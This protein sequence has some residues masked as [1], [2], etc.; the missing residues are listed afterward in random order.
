[1]TYEQAVGILI[2]ILRSKEA[3]NYEQAAVATTHYKKLLTDRWQ[4][5]IAGIKGEAGIT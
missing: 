1:M 5:V 4:E 2:L 3:E